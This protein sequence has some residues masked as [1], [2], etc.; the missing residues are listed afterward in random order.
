MDA[1]IK[2]DTVSAYNTLRGVPTLHPLIAV[3]DLSK[4]KPMPAV[5]F[6]F[7]VYAI[8]LKELKCGELKYGR[9]YYDYQEGT[10]VLFHRDKY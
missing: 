6:N 1:I 7:G 8:F 2:L 4:S 5:T 3:L 9:N 10:L